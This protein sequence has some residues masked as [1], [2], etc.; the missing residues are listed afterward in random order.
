MA[1][2]KRLEAPS[3][4][5]LSALEQS[6][7]SDRPLRSPG[8]A[9]PPIAQVAAEA[10]QAAEIA[11]PE[12]RATHARLAQ[13][14]ERLRQAEA[15]GLLIVEIPID[16]IK[17]DFITRDRVDLDPEAMVELIAS[18][19]A[20]GMRLPIEVCALGKGE[21][22]L[23]S[24]YRR[25]CAVRDIAEAEGL[26]PP[27]IR[28]LV[29]P[30]TD[31]AHGLIAMVEENEVRSDLTPYERGRIAII[32]VRDGTFASLE[33][34]VNALFGT[35]S[36][37]KRSKIRSFARV[38]DAFGDA[39]A[40]GPALKERD[41]LALASALKSGEGARVTAALKG[42]RPKTAGEE[43]NAIRTALSAPA[44][45][46]T[47]PPKKR[48]SARPAELSETVHICDGVSLRYHRSDAGHQIRFMGWRVD[49]DLMM[50][51]MGELE[52]HLK[53]QLDGGIRP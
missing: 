12:D 16:Q 21:Y 32:A 48:V 13:D 7:I 10:A 30:T 31:R 33:D 45:R 51:L 29:Q 26:A 38:F 22:G 46:K 40:F 52:A 11:S 8:I 47:T 4:D 53:D 25:L 39:L 49:E 14:A 24:G 17:I 9:A 18:V 6:L 34:A 23:I 42:K 37:A 15:S 3:A 44:G 20:N 1:K 41:G 5:A 27:L 19:R 28:A 36:K 50:H 2:R 43:L 35:A